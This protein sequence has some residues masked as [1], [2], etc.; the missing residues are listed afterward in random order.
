[1]M[2]DDETPDTRLFFFFFLIFLQNISDKIQ[3]IISVDWQFYES[4][5]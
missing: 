5:N 4:K 1:M 3:I 2:V